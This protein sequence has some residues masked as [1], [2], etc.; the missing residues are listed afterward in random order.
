MHTAV[1]A[2]CTHCGGEDLT[3][4]MSRFAF[5]RS[6]TDDDF[7]DDLDEAALMEGLDENDPQSVARWARKMSDKLGED[8]GPEFDDMVGRME[9]GEMPE[10]DDDGDDF[11]GD[12]LDDDLE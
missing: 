3:R 1:A 12:G 8:L 7:G 11:G 2:R 6:S 5:H 9:R 4:L 10:D